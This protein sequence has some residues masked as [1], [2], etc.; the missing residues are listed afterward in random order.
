MKNEDLSGSRKCLDASDSRRIGYVYGVL[1]GSFTALSWILC[2]LS[3]KQALWLGSRIGD[4]SRRI[5]KKK[6]R[7]VKDNY[8]KA[9]GSNHRTACCF[10]RDVFR[11]FG[12]MGVEFLRF[13]IMDD[14][15]MEKNVAV[16]GH[17]HFQEA[18][19]SGR[20]A[21]LLSAHAGNWELMLKKIA[22]FS[23]KRLMVLNRPIKNAAIHDFIES[24]RSRFGKTD[25]I[26]S[27]S[28]A[29]PIFRHLL[30]NG[31]VGVVLDQ[32]AGLRDGIFVPFF[33]RMAAT[34]SSIARISIRSGSP[35]L[36]IFN[37]RNSDGTYKV[38]VSPPVRPEKSGRIEDEILRL[39]TVYTQAIEGHIRSYPEQWIWM[40]RRWKTRPENEWG[41]K[42]NEPA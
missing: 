10:E 11:H 7:I 34:Y 17:E 29:Q 41:L 40:H 24:Y 21:M 27:G 20:G 35:V 19:S 15:W 37:R 5:L 8:T 13:P 25:S 4:L 6:G 22:C 30:K 42:Q 18:I 31:L 16:E 3:Q 38:T 23:E 12:V 28:A 1:F 39:T 32:N 33:G 2:H 9:F 26:L 36:P 14:L